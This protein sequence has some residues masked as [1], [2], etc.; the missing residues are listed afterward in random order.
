MPR[1]IEMV[2]GIIGG[3]FGVLGAVGATMIGIVGEAFGAEG[4]QTLYMGAGLAIVASIVGIVAAVL[5]RNRP[6]MSGVMMVFA[7]V[8]GLIGIS[9]F[10]VLSTILL[11]VAGIM[12]LVR[13]VETPVQPTVGSATVAAGRFCTNCGSPLEANVKFCG[14]CG[15]SNP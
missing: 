12:A 11:G 14:K 2:F 8:L 4:T 9:L 6:R 15:T 7:A 1:T 5:V 13:K 3:I 10:F